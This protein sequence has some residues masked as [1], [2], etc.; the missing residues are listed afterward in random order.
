[1][2][3]LI[4][5]GYG[6]DHT[7]MLEMSDRLEMVRGE[8]KADTSVGQYAKKSKPNELCPCGSGKKF[9]KCCLQSQSEGKCDGKCDCKCN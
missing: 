4:R 2:G 6:Q 7:R 8:L 9:K 5:G 1:M 3:E